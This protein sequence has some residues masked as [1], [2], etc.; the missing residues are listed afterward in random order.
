MPSNLLSQ[1]FDLYKNS[2]KEKNAETEIVDVQ[3]CQV[4]NSLIDFYSGFNGVKDLVRSN[5]YIF[6]HMVVTC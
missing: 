4:L 6:V 5:E 2:D 1:A 3:F